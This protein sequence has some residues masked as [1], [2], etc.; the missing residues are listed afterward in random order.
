MSKYKVNHTIAAI[1]L[2][3]SFFA[4]WQTMVLLGALLF[5]FCEMEDRLKNLTV[6]LISFSIGLKL[7]EIF[8][9]IIYSASNLIPEILEKLVGIINYYLD[10]YDAISLTKFQLYVINPIADLFDIGNSIFDYL[11]IIAS[12]VFI[13]SLLIGVNKK[14]FVIDKL[15][16]K[17]VNNVIRC[18]T[19]F[20]TPQVAPVMQQQPVSQQTVAA[21]PVQNFNNQVL[22][23]QNIN[24]AQPNN[25]VQ[26]FNG[27]QNNMM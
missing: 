15:I 13:T 3:A 19:Q 21:A 11:V 10:P 5:I 23:N 6:S 18:V 17:Y 27:Q 14:G 2:I 26:N 1:L 24:N 20:G 12:F 8:W 7:V 22:Q 4:S 9:G 25:N 16:T